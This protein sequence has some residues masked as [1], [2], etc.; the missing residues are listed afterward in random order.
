MN[1]VWMKF[2]GALRA[3]CVARAGNVAITFALATIP[4]IAG[5]GFAVDYSRANQVKVALQAA[6]DST[7]LMISKEAAKDTPDQL[8]ANAL[9]YFTALFTPTS[10]SNATIAATYS[11]TGGTQVVINGSANVATSFLGLIGYNNMAV[12]TSSTVRWGSTRLRVALVLDNTGSMADNNKIGALRTATANLLTQL[13]NA[14]STNGD[15]YVSIIPFVKDVNLG[16]SEWNS[17]WIYWGTAAQDTTLSDNN[18]WDAN[19]GSCSAGNYSTRSSCVSH[20]SCS[21]SGYSSQSSCTSAGTCSLSGYTSSSSCTGAGTCSISGRTSQSTCTT[22]TCSLSGYTSQNS[23]TGAGTCSISGHTS[24][25]SCQSAGKCSKS[26]YT[27]SS[28]CSQHSGT[29]TTGVWTA[30]VWTAG[31]TWTAGV[32]T[33]GVW[34]AATWTPANHNTWNGCVMDRG[35]STTPDT[36]NNYDTNVVQP[37]VT[38]NTSL[39]AAEQYGSCPQAVMGLSYD[40]TTMNQLVTNMSPNGN[41]N[42]AI[43]LQLGWMSLVGGGPFTAPALDPNYTYTQVIILLTDGLNTQ[44][45]WYTSQNSIDARQTLTCS[46]IKAAGITLYTI[47]VN[48]GNDP[49]STLLQNCASSSDKFFLLTSANQIVTTFN[50]IGTNLSNLYVAK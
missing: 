40:W 32:W 5:V 47:Q 50:Q 7:A 35:N 38:K 46:N 19:N 25:S 21:I 20:S 4:I 17:D 30:G 41:T 48:T 26:Q 43:G 15:V 31:G 49:T 23:C 44:D 28:T 2:R 39:Y 34:S 33:A 12:S 16:S 24:Q 45:R 6:L 29:W 10:A 13:Q 42:Q 27:S 36:V 37:D 22:G 8:Q 14:A 11:T 9:K 3:F 18:S 1:S